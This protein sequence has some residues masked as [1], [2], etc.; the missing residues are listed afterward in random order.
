M[1][2]MHKYAGLDIRM[3]S[4][5]TLTT[6]PRRIDKIGRGPVQPAAGQANQNA[7]PAGALQGADRR[8]SQ[9]FSERCVEK[10]CIFPAIRGPRG[11]C[12]YHDRQQREPSCFHSQ[13]PSHLLLERA[14]FGV[15]DP[16]AEHTRV[17]DRRLLVSLREVFLD[18]V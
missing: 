11:I 1:A 4:Y 13:Q 15:T 16:E 9:L 14:K 8:G 10:G 5:V 18:V 2:D 7:E 3:S 17:R 6:G 12:L